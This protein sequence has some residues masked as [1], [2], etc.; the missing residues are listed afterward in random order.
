[1]RVISKHCKEQLRRDIQDWLHSDDS[2]GLSLREILEKYPDNKRYFPLEII[3]NTGIE[4]L[5]SLD[6]QG[7]IE[8]STKEKRGMIYASQTRL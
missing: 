8:W 7:Y 5:V 3:G 4:Y 6:Q 2:G 1:M